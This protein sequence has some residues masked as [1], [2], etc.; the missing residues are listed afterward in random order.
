MYARLAQLRG[1]SWETL[2]RSES[3]IG[4]FREATASVSARPGFDGSGEGVFGVLRHESGVHRV[5]RVP[6]NDTRIHTSAA[7]YL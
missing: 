5:Q 6:A 4:G 2:S 3:Q 7:R 1:W